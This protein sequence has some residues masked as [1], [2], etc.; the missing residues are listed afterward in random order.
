[1]VVQSI[2]GCGVE[3]WKCGNVE[4]YTERFLFENS[5]KKEIYMSGVG[6][7]DV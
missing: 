2:F 1:M 4:M 6:L 7:G 3:M 5:Y